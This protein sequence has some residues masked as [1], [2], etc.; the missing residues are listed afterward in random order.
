MKK[1]KTK[2]NLDGGKYR[3]GQLHRRAVRGP[4]RDGRVQQAR[5]NPYIKFARAWAL[6][7]GLSYGIAL[8]NPQLPIDYRKSKAFKNALGAPRPPR[9]PRQQRP[10]LPKDVQKQ[11]ENFV[12]ELKIGGPPIKSSEHLEEIR[13]VQ[14]LK[15]LKPLEKMHMKSLPEG[16]L[17][18]IKEGKKLRKTAKA[19]VVKFPSRIT[20]ILKP[21][22]QVAKESKMEQGEIK[23][24][25]VVKA[26]QRKAKKLLSQKALTKKQNKKEGSKKNPYVVFMKK[27]AKDHGVTYGQA[28]SSQIA[29][30]QYHKQEE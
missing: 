4:V 17:K 11:I 30:S 10:R 9:P 26:N 16:T 2:K 12:K 21:K 20:R 3:R 13:E 18:E 7:H 25:K 29:N 24:Q 6:K 22:K 28:L 8:Q 27:Y 23:K 14:K 1:Q 19:N 15:K 5:E